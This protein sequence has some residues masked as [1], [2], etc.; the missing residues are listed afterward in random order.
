MFGEITNSSFKGKYKKTKDDGEQ[1]TLLGLSLMDDFECFGYLSDDG[2]SIN[3]SEIDPKK[4]ITI[5]LQRK[6]IL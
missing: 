2:N 4:N 6:I 3:I 1:Q 5:S